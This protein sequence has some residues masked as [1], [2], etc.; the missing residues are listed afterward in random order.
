[1]KF[2]RTTVLTRFDS[3]LG[4]I[5]AAASEQGLCGLWFEGQRHLPDM[6]GW[7]LAPQHPLLQATQA[8]M[9]AYFEGDTSGFDLPLDLHGGTPFQQDVW[10]ALLRI[11]SGATTSYGALSHGLG[12]PS[13]V[14][15]VAGAVGRNPISV[16]VPCHRVLGSDGSL[17][18]Y[19][20][21]LE[22]KTALLQLEATRQA[23][24]L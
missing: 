22:R 13:A 17:T 7:P 18:G 4:P 23:V 19:A 14:R 8:H 11:P 15:A 16:I 9:Q 2:S 6:S 3:P 21:G 24:L 1:M 5:L 10:Q 12:R 20:G